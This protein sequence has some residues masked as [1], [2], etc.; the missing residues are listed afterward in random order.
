[1]YIQRSILLSFIVFS[2]VAGVAGCGAG[3]ELPPLRPQ[4]TLSGVIADEN[5]QD[6]TV[7]VFSLQ[8]A[9]KGV[10]L[11]ETTVNDDG[12]YSV[13]IRAKSQ[14]ILIEVSGGVYREAASG[15]SVALAEGV[16]LRA[17]VNYTSGQPLSV[18]VSPLTHIG[19]ALAL[20]ETS[21]GRDLTAV[22]SE[23]NETLNQVFEF[24]TYKT[25]AQS[26]GKISEAPTEL[27]PDSIYGFYLAGIS[28]WTKWVSNEHGQ[29][30]HN[31]YNTIGLSRIVY[32]DVLADGLLNGRGFDNADGVPTELY[33]GKIRLDANVYRISFAQHMLAIAGSPENKTT[34]SAKKLLDIAH[35]LATSRHPIFGDRELGEFAEQ[36]PS[37]YALESENNYQ[38]G[39]FHF[40]VALGGIVGAETVEF[41]VDG[42]S[43]GMAGDSLKPFADINTKLYEDGEH[44]IEVVA[45]NVFEK[46][47][48][49]SFTF[50]FDNAGPIVKVL[51]PL[52]TNQ[53]RYKLS[54]TYSDSGVGV[55]S[56]SV[57]GVD[58]AVGADGGWDTEFVL[59]AGK[60]SVPIVVTDL[61]DNQAKQEIVVALDQTSPVIDTNAG[62]GKAEFVSVDGPV[63]KL[64]SDNNI[65]APLLIETNRIDLNSVGIN[66]QSLGENKTP[67]FAFTVSDPE[68]SDVSSSFEEINV[69][70]QYKINDKII[71]DWDDDLTLVGNEYLVP[72][73][74]ETLNELWDRVN[75]ND[76][77]AIVVKA[78][79]KAGNFFQKQFTYKV[80]FRVAVLSENSIV[81][82]IK[83]EV[84]SYIKDNDGVLNFIARNDLYN[85]ELGVV[86][87]QFKNETG[88]AYYIRLQDVGL[89]KLSRTY[90]QVVTS[91][92]VYQTTAK[93]WRVRYIEN[94]LNACSEI[95][96]N[97]ADYETWDQV[98]ELNPIYNYD[99]EDPSKWIA[100]SPPLPITDT[101]AKELGRNTPVMEEY[102]EWQDVADFD[103]KYAIRTEKGFNQTLAYLYDYIQ[104]PNILL[105]TK[106]ATILSW[107]LYDDITGELVEQC[108]DVQNFKQRDIYTYESDTGYPRNVI[109]KSLMEVVNFG[110]YGFEVFDQEAGVINPINGWYRIPPD[111]LITIRKIVVNPNL[112]YYEN[113]EVT[114][115]EEGVESFES[116]IPKR[117]DDALMWEISKK[118]TISVVH[119][120]GEENLNKMSVNAFDVGDGIS[121]YTL[122]R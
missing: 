86:E 78:V 53:Q 58:V 108:P 57:Y 79:D 99:P 122:Q 23:S 100:K 115:A 117:Y 35:V 9:D 18:M 43:V 60:N 27:A 71:S 24:D 26:I 17:L 102:G 63:E 29:E 81:D 6:S 109:S 85:S 42:L 95:T 97:S 33:Y 1:M 70:F 110:T 88:G 98:T 104:E 72:L 92:M 16:N 38:N 67:Y 4:G 94:P 21:K 50:R 7:R 55:K 64:L 19:T 3:F 59:G 54:G 91:N 76:S 46:S 112:E 40:A 32:D 62:H 120:A 80:D 89:H 121:T 15:N 30:A 52:V 66:R 25:K 106:P 45:T 84:E 116:Y 73:T 65:E 51:S 28:S 2:L 77:H 69:F 118:I 103:N 10:L 96:S 114:T 48:T 20:F 49:A 119:D 39:T 111:H 12:S 34:I 82:T 11:G 14:P 75:P 107:Q 31:V 93:D 68:E 36:A 90:D 47:N 83:N 105:G 101:Q 44:D 56:L 13:D 22:V 74:T 87:Y 5:M 113:E 41:F 8:N 37:I 61:L